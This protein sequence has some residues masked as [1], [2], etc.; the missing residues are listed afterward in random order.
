MGWLDKL[1]SG[2][3]GEGGNEVGSARGTIPHDLPLG[4]RIGGQVQFD[5]TLYRIA[6][7]AMTAELPGG[8]QG[9][10]CYGHVDLGDGYALHRFYLDDD[11]FVQVSTVGGEIEGVKGFVY[12]ETV[13]PPSKQAFQDFV[14][15][16]PHL[17]EDAI[18]YAGRRW[19]RATASTQAHGRIPAIAYDETLYRYQPPRRDGDLTHY[20]MLYR[21][22]V[23][24]LQR[25]EF[26]LVTGEDSG[27]N[28]F[29]VTY[30][31]GMD[32]SSADFDVT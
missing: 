30:A 3:R 15:R 16:S 12:Y 24:E 29:C 32:L 26:L 4:L 7:G 1:F 8:Y 14:M 2:K 21:R 28:E 23:P 9:V 13:N 20:A 31:V 25:E 18:D 6:P 17:G 5:T 10:P 19:V 27:P 11:A 22:D